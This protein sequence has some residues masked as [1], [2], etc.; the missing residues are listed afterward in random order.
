MFT[1]KKNHLY[2][3][4]FLLIILLL[5]A[6][7]DRIRQKD[8]IR[9]AQSEILE[10]Y[11]YL[12]NIDFYS[13]IVINN[14]Y[15]PLIEKHQKKFIPCLA[16]KW[17]NPDKNSIIIT[18][19]KNVY[20]HNGHLFTVRDVIASVK[21]VWKEKPAYPIKHLNPKL[22]SILDDYS[23]K[24]NDIPEDLNIVDFFSKILIADGRIIEQFTS[25]EFSKNPVG[26]GA[27]LFD[28]CDQKIIRFKR[29]P[30]YWG[31]KPEIENIEI[32]QINK[33][34]Q[35]EKLISEEVDVVL[36]PSHNK[37]KKMQKHKNIHINNCIGDLVLYLMLDANRVHS[38]GIIN[39]ENPFLNNKMR[40]A[41][42][43]SINLD[44][45][46]SNEFCGSACRSPLPLLPTLE[47]FD[48]SLSIYEYNPEK[49]KQ[50]LKEANIELPLKIE[51]DCI[52]E[53]FPADTEIGLFIKDQLKEIG[54]EVKL[55]FRNSKDFYSKINKKNSSAY[56]TGYSYLNYDF[57]TPAN[58]L[59]S[60]NGLLNRFNNEI[61][62]LSILF[63]SFQDD[64][65]EKVKNE[66]S[67][68]ISKKLYNS[69]YI[70]PLYIPDYIVAINK[71]IRWDSK[72]ILFKEINYRKF[73]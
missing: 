21:R 39:R 41:L 57:I 61:D 72:S 32:I 26:T 24:V 60:K 36:F 23:F 44:E 10:S 30:N 52:K 5:I 37:V 29:N 11:D 19:K 18:L 14:I 12:Y 22:I 51:I 67:K 42:F 66:I 2:K 50:L 38:P 62:S 28:Y 16:E 48:S 46:I 27:Y 68:K 25:N 3:Y 17:I 70:I 45:F 54:I 55:N 7:S 59:Y 40:E 6:C 15:E 63:A 20:F 58:L 64:L 4:F 71:K 73:K 13:L 53:K 56:I 8:T 31:K 49:A 47:G 65:D 33:D 9:I 69:N 35:V 43:Y 34:E 1:T